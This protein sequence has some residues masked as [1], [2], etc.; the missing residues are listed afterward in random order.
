[1]KKNI[2]LLFV[3]IINI[4]CFADNETIS[5]LKN[6]YNAFIGKRHGV[7]YSVDI[8]VNN[9]IVNDDLIMLSKLKEIKVISVGSKKITDKGLT[10]LKDNTNLKVLFFT[11]TSITGEGFKHLKNL[12]KLE[13]LELQ[14]T[15][16]NDE[17]LKYISE[18][19]FEKGLEIYLDNTKITD[20]GLEYLQRVE[21]LGGTLRLNNT[22]V[23][24]A[25]LK[26]LAKHINLYEIDFTGT[27]VTLKGMD[28]LKKYLKDTHLT[29]NVK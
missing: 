15:K 22:A 25:G 29:K 20:K 13:R 16:L 24:D 28:W 7:L 1:M 9:K 17:G 27:K 6:K 18:I 23:T 26:Y 3:F 21:N 12:T 10:Y 8:G 14:R 11:D 5:I 4:S 2:V 19:D